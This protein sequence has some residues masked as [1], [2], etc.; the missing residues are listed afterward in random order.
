MMN[1]YASDFAL[2][3]NSPTSKGR[4]C[5]MVI[6]QNKKDVCVI[7]FTSDMIGQP[8]HYTYLEK[9][10]NESITKSVNLQFKEG[11][12]DLPEDTRPSFLSDLIKLISKHLRH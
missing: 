6:Q 2:S 12:V 3:F 5:T 7:D 8:C 9:R 11:I 4:P 10:E 1:I